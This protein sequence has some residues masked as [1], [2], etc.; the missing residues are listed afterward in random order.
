MHRAFLCM[1][2]VLTTSGVML[3]QL[4]IQTNA[5]E[6]SSTKDVEIVKGASDQ[7]NEQFFVPAEIQVSTGG[8]VKWTNNDISIHTATAGT[9]GQGP[10]QQFDSG[11]ISPKGTYEN[12]FTESGS[13]DYYCTLHPWMISKVF[14]A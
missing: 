8:T 2:V 1:I 5:Q 12:I 13:I 6:S 14:V 4:G 3:A 9:P 10:S 7:N 11:L